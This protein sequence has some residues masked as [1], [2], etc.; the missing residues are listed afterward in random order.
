LRKLYAAGDILNLPDP[1]KDTEEE[2]KLVELVSNILLG[3]PLSE[4]IIEE[5]GPR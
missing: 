2:Q 3:K 1:S 4:I 5:R